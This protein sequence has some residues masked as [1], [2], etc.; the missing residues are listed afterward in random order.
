[1]L[2]AWW[3][4]SRSAPPIT[5]FNLFLAIWVAAGI[6][7]LQ[8]LFWVKAPKV[9]SALLAVA[10]GWLLVPYLG[11]VRRALDGVTV[12]L[13]LIGGIA[14]TVGAVAYALK[15]PNPKPGVF[16]YHEVFHLLTLVGAATH[17]AAV[18]LIVRG[19]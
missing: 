6:G 14:Y 12:M 8:S 17:F 19:Q 10:V 15:W 11:D 4:C 1:M 7:V 2:S 3:R 9:V 5:G 13:L 18:V 16:G